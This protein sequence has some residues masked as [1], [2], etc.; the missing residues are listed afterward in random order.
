VGD[1][2]KEPEWTSLPTPVLGCILCQPALSFS[3]LDYPLLLLI[4]MCHGHPHHHPCGHQSVKWHY[5]PRALIDLDTGYET[6]CDK[7][8]FASSQ[9]SKASCPLQ[10]CEFKT[11]GTRWICC[12]CKQGPNERGWC[13]FDRPHWE[14]NHLTGDWAW[15]ESCDHGCCKNCTGSRG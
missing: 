1:G 10:K 3:S 15:V 12:A 11:H 5:C 7:A 14:Q 2:A 8:T 4:P 9:P 13:A 6:S